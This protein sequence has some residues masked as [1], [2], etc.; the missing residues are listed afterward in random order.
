MRIP[1]SKVYR[2]F[3]ELDAFSDGE[4][5]TFVQLAQRERAV[6]LLSTAMG[7]V[8]VAVCVGAMA[9]YVAWT[10]LSLVLGEADLR[11][12]NDV[13]FGAY[14]SL[15]GF[16]AIFFASLSG[17]VIRDLWIRWAIARR[18]GVARCS[19]CNYSLLGLSV[20]EDRVKCPECGTVVCLSDRGL[21]PVDILAGARE[22][23]LR[24]GVA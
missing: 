23:V 13:R 20:I 9:G 22:L 15:T 7:A 6:G 10:G 12:L 19:R 17:L 2:A 16:A 24:D 5:R 3:P 8:V 1:Y 18:L 21:K 14:V 11:P 4:C